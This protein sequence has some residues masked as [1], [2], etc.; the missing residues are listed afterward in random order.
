MKFIDLSHVIENVQG[1]PEDVKINQISHEDGAALLGKKYALDKDDFPNGQAI[2]TERIRLTT[3]SG[4]H[5]DAPYHFGRECMGAKAKTIEQIPLE[6]CFGRGVLI[7]LTY[8]S[9]KIN[10]ITKDEIQQFL[11]DNKLRIE[12]GDIVLINSGADKYWN[13][14]DYFTSYRGVELEATKYILSHGVKVIGIDSFGFDAPFDLMAEKYHKTGDSADLWP[15]H[16]LGRDIEY[17]H[18]ERLTN[19]TALNGIENFNVS[20]FPIA[21]QGAGAGWARVVALYH[22]RTR[23]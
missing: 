3:H 16:V 23:G 17:C 1:E 7:D 22:T 2:N 5:L 19:L 15:S 13:T 10:S 4:T 20:C 11:S 6:W 8:N 14:P 9:D 21:I 18:I 12:S